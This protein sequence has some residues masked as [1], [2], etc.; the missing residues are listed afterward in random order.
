MQG[1]GW[2]STQ[3]SVTSCRAKGAAGGLRVP[4]AV[5]NSPGRGN[6]GMPR[7]VVLA[8]AMVLIVV[9]AR[10]ARR[11]ISGGSVWQEQGTAYTRR[12][13]RHEQL[14]SCITPFCPHVDG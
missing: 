5:A 13:G 7:A 14:V 1:Q 9:P 10:Q 12:V 2:W 8:A 4:T 6:F 3:L 11:K